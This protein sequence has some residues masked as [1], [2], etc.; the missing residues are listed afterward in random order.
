MAFHC[1]E[2]ACRF[3]GMIAVDVFALFSNRAVV[4]KLR[5]IATYHFR[6]KGEVTSGA[7]AFAYRQ[8]RFYVKE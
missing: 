5:I 1:R 3:T 7:K 2:Y 6:V 4:L 8:R